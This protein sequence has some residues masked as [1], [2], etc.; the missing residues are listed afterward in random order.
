MSDATS[1]AVTSSGDSSAPK[2]SSGAPNVQCAAAA[3]YV[4][5]YLQSVLGVEELLRMERMRQE[6][7]VKE[8]ISAAAVRVARAGGVQTPTTP[9]ALMKTRSVPNMQQQLQ[10]TVRANTIANVALQL[11]KRNR[12][13]EALH[14][15]FY[16][17]LRHW[18]RLL[19]ASQLLSAV[20]RPISS[21]KHQSGL[22][23]MRRMSFRLR[24]RSINA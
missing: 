18:R 13:Y 19:A 3:E 17:A 14:H 2:S 8:A 12:V 5:K 10:V 4:D 1:D 9:G 20:M 24:K 6:L 22:S 11:L 7:R 15:R 23:P 16:P 21:P